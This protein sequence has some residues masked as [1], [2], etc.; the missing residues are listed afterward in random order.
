MTATKQLIQSITE[1]QRVPTELMEYTAEMIAQIRVT[2]EAQEGLAAF[3]E[4][5]A[6]N[7]QEP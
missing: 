3:L 6:P 2:E 4:K 7:W 1:E 5:R